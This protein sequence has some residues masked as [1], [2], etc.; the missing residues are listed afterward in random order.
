MVVFRLESSGQE[1]GPRSS[2]SLLLFLVDDDAIA[3]IPGNVNK[4]FVSCKQLTI[5]HTPVTFEE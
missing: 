4:A 1:P 3:T 2:T 5:H